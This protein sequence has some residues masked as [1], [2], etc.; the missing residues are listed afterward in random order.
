[1]KRPDLSILVAAHKEGLIAH[2]T[3]LSVE[4]AVRRLSENGFSYEIIVTIDNGDSE[5]VAYFNN[6]LLEFQTTYEIHF[7]DLAASRNFAISK[8]RSNYIA[9]V[10][11]DDLIS[12]NWFLDGLKTLLANSNP[13]VLHTHYSVNFGTQDIVWEKYNSRSKEEDALI[14]TWANRW[15]SAIM[16]PRSVFETFPYQPNTR[17]FGSE[18]WHF[19]SQTLAADIPH[20]I[21]PETALFV[22]RKD[23]SEMT[24]Q[25]A[26]RRTVHY[27]DLLSLDFLKSIDVTPYRTLGIKNTERLTPVTFLRKSKHAVIET[28]R[29]THVQAK[30]LDA[31]RK[32][33]QPLLDYRK[34]R[35]FARIDSRFPAWLMEAWRA[36]HMIDKSIFPSR[37]LLLEIPIYHSEMY[38][39]GIALH[40]MA[41]SIPTH[42]DYIMI[43]PALRPGG[44]EVVMLNFIKALNVV[45]P[46]WKIGVVTTEK[47]KNAWKSRLPANVAFID[48]GN[49]THDFSDQL[50][51]LLLAR[52]IV[53][54]KATH[55][56]LAQS[57]LGFKFAEQYQSF[58][59]N[60][61]I[62][63]FAFCEDTNDEGLIA[64]HVHT[65]IPKAYPIITKT[66]SDHRA[67]IDELVTE[68]AFDK[69]KFATHYQPV[70]LPIKPS[71]GAHKPL[72]ILW[73]S[74]ITK[75]K[76]P[77]I[78][79]KIAQNIDPTKAHIDAYGIF[80]HTY[81]HHF[82]SGIPSLSYKG[83][84]SD[85]S[86]LNAA[87]YDVFLYT[88]ENDG[89]PNILLEMISN[90]LLVIAP[91]IGGIP[92]L[93]S[94]NTGILIDDFTDILAYTAAINDLVTNYDSYRPRVES[95]Q[96]LIQERHTF[97]Y[98]VKEVTKDL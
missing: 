66:F 74:R 33:L 93:I 5:T 38:E 10:D 94:N 55:L 11:A 39:L 40:D 32:I 21:V 3:M 1:M 58:L 43:L 80:E 28:L 81:D 76:R 62:F 29:F 16:A 17:G 26:D 83:K 8:A 22:R 45:H 15:D 4:H 67:V 97:N 90:G 68:Y 34:Q 54:S 52:L 53:Q 19:N 2:K 82:L 48:F 71:H 85:V 78:L 88:S 35:K 49:I 50:K 86:Q 75:Q 84:F 18:D 7:G 63:S 12:E 51:M 72:K 31:Y 98:L 89:I 30:K 65:G 61:T 42:L 77:D 9:T 47:N 73:A 79:K 23:V 95:A 41:Q 64:G 37:E 57:L 69:E 87:D 91:K 44:A 36:A 6:H 60:Y 46:D 56:H 13:R 14:M 24:I 59:K 96:K 20:H 25:A 70:E 92:E 27:T